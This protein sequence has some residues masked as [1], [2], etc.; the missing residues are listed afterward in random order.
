MSHPNKSN[1]FNH[2]GYSCPRTQY[3]PALWDENEYCSDCLRGPQDKNESC[4]TVKQAKSKTKA[5][6][7]LNSTNVPMQKN[8]DLLP[9]KKYSELQS[10]YSILENNVN[11]L[12]LDYNK[13]IAYCKEL[14]IDNANLENTNDSL[15]EEK[16]RLEDDNGVLR[17]KYNDSVFAGKEIID[18]KRANG[19]WEK[20]TINLK[21]EN[22]FFKHKY[23]AS[24]QE[25]VELRCRIANMS[26]ELNQKNLKV[27]F[28]SIQF[29]QYCD[30]TIYPL[31]N[32]K[33]GIA[34]IRKRIKEMY[35][36][37]MNVIKA[38]KSCVPNK[39]SEDPFTMG[40]FMIY[41][42]ITIQQSKN[43]NAQIEIIQTMLESMDKY[44]T[45]IETAVDFENKI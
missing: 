18:L 1:K 40:H 10:E 44:L 12:V 2:S 25:N 16:N 13:L 3:C 19:Q 35:S 22:N 30:E 41:C 23:S 31:K 5:K 15:L 21:H 45:D 14:E 17:T 37:L 28:S 11:L 39:Q 6:P 36:Y 7:K 34:D 27:D 8:D 24:E 38:G 4:P 42:D 32:K 43:R 9:Q 26:R 20:E 33:E 29:I